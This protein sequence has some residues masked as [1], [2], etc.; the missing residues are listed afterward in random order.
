MDHFTV[1]SGKTI[2]ILMALEIVRNADTLR[3]VQIFTDNQNIIHAVTNPSA[4]SAEQV[5][6]QVHLVHKQIL[7]PV[8]V[9]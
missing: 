8:T 7:N 5:I 6:R 4:R 3:P 2:G 9:H 1:Y